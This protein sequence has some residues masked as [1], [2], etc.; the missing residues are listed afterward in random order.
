MKN[1]A[2]VGQLIASGGMYRPNGFLEA[3]A[4]VIADPAAGIADLHVYTF[5]QVASTESWRRD[6]L[7]ALGLGRGR[8]EPGRGPVDRGRPSMTPDSGASATRSRRRPGCR[9]GGRLVR[10]AARTRPPPPASGRRARSSSISP[11]SRRRSGMRASTPSPARTSRTGPGRSPASGP[12]PGDDALRGRA[13]RLRRDVEQPPW[14]ALMGSLPTVGRIA[15]ATTPTA[16][17]MSPRSSGSPWTTTRSTS[18]RSGAADDS[19]A[20]SPTRAAAREQHGR[21]GA[22][23]RR[24]RR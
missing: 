12:G 23:S 17:W 13:R 1:T 2:F 9:R 24:H 4:P 5:N 20:A 15:A 11:R 6:Y 10:R 8:P 21:D 16:S 7:A 19:G 3:V 18:P 22:A 14:R